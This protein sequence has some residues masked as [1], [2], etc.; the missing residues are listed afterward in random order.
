MLEALNSNG[1]KTLDAFF[2]YKKFNP[3]TYADVD[4]STGFMETVLTYVDDLGSRQSLDYIFE[5][6]YEEKVDNSR[7]KLKLDND[8]FF[9]EKFLVNQISNIQNNI[10]KSK[11]MYSQLSDHYG[12]SCEIHYIR[13]NF[14]NQ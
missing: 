1:I 3:I 10:E 7:K 13:I 6:F 2:H 5:C 14:I 12:L 9:I 4:Q 8:N 11:K